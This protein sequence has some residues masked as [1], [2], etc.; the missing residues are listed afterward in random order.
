MSKAPEPGLPA[1]EQ[2]TIMGVAMRMG[3]GVMLALGPPYRHH[4]L[5][6]FGRK[7]GHG[8]D[9]LDSVQGFLTSQ[10]VFLGREEALVVAQAA[11]QLVQ[12]THPLDKLYSEDLW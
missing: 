3:K 6:R 12:K 4:D 8:D 9:T 7:A 10:G 1:T 11:G 2:V 5:F